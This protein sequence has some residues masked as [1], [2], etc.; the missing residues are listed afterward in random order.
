MGKKQQKGQERKPIRQGD[1]FLIPV[2]DIPKTAKEESVEGDIILALG[3]VTGHQHAFQRSLDPCVDLM[4][5][6]SVNFLR[7]GGGGAVLAHGSPA[8]GYTDGDHAPVEVPM[9]NWRVKLQNEYRW[10][11]ERQVQD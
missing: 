3:E 11:E 2:S 1:V 10:G 5:D 6:D 9:G 4:R 7:I 8:S